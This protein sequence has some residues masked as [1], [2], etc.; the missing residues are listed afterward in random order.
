MEFDSLESCISYIKSCMAVAAPIVGEEM[1][2]IMKQAI[3]TD[4]YS[5][6]GNT[7]GT[8]TGALGN[9]AEITEASMNGVTTEYMDNGGWSSAIT[10]EGFFPLEKG[11]LI[12]LSEISKPSSRTSFFKSSNEAMFF[13]SRKASKIL[14]IRPR[15]NNNLQFEI[16][17]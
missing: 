6:H 16:A 4:I 13:Q 7:T 8:R 5:A 11:V 12:S 14:F 3:E 15:S 17:I 9:C 1:K 10:G 2:E